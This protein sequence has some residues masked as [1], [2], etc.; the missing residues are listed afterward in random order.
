[1][2]TLEYTGVYINVP[3]ETEKEFLLDFRV[4]RWVLIAEDK[5]SNY[6]TFTFCLGC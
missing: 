6:L 5:H 4:I 3:P 2:A 1:M